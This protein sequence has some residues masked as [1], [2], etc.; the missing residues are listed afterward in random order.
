MWKARLAIAGVALFSLVAVVPSAGAAPVVR[1][2]AG[3][4]V[5]SITPTVDLF[6]ADLGAPAAQRQIVWDGVPDARAAPAFM[7]EGQFRGVGALF[8]TPGIG[9]QVSQ[10]LAPL[11]FGEINPTYSTAFAPFSAPRLFTAFGSNVTDTTFVVAGTN[12]RA[13]TSDVDLA[14]TTSIQLF[15]AAGAS[16]GTFAVPAAGN[17]NA[18]FSFLG[19]SFNAGERVALARITSGAAALATGVD[20]VTQGGPSD[21]VTMDN[22]IFGDPAAVPPPVVVPPPPPVLP[23]TTPPTVTL[24]GVPAAIRLKGLRNNGIPVRMTPNEPVSFRV[25][26][27]ASVGKVRVAANELTLASRSLGRAAGERSVRLRPARRLLRDTAK[28]FRVRVVVAATDAGG[29]T[30]TVRRTVRVRR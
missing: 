8:A 28:R 21:L 29:N 17:S 16:L 14:G 30:T 13:Q 9:F 11:N 22:F 19:V 7:P 20:D 5:G 10:A 26:L 18:T 27:L 6:R 15:D 1:Q 12:T 25:A 3:A 23:D 24:K 4:D 2:A